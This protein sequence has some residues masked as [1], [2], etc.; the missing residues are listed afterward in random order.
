MKILYIP[1]IAALIALLPMEY[2]GYTLVRIIICAFLVYAGF[3]TKAQGSPNKERLGT[4]EASLIFFVIAAIYNPVFPLH[5]ARALWML[6][7]IGVAIYI[8][9]F[10]NLSNTSVSTKNK[11]MKL[12]LKIPDEEKISEKG[13]KLMST[14][15]WSSLASL[16]LLLIFSFLF[17]E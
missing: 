1:A 6:I 11:D 10:V 5:L 7:D 8:F 17:K 12:D 14:L 2:D 3:R 15:L 16:V 9:W 13:D 4:D